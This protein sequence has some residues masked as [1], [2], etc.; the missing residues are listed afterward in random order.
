[1]SKS[2]SAVIKRRI[3]AAMFVI[4]F[5][6]YGILLVRLFQLQILESE[7]FQQEAQE[8]QFRVSELSAERGVIYDTNGNK[9]AMS[10][11]A[12]NICISPAEIKNDTQKELVISGLS[13]ILGVKE[14]YV[15][16]KCERKNY[17]QVIKA[18]VEKAAVEEVTTFAAANGLSKCIYVEENVSRKYPYEN[19]ASTVIGFL[20]A[21]NVASYGL[22]AYYDEILSGTSGKLI[23]ARDSW[24]QAMPFEYDELYSSEDGNS[25]VTTIDEGIQYFVEKHLELAVKEHSV[26][27]RGACIAMDVKTGKILAMATK[28]DFDPNLYTELPES[29]IEEIERLPEDERGDATLSAQYDMW[30][31]KAISDPYEPGS[32]FKIITLA[33]A[34]DANTATLGDH[35]SC[36]GYANVADRKISCWQS[37]G[38]GDQTLADAVQ[39]SC[40]P[41]FIQIGLNMGINNFEYY[42]EAFGLTEKTGIDL[43][44]EATSIYYTDGMTE[45]NLASSSFGQTFKVTPIQLVTAVSAAVNGGNLY[46]PY[47]VQKVLSSDGSI[48]EEYEPTLVRQVISEQ[49]S[50][51]VVDIL[52][53]V[54]SDGSGRTAA[55]P[56]Y[57]I[58]G[59][60]G[61]SEKLD[62][63]NAEG[64]VE[65]YVS[66]FLAVAPIEDPQIVIL[67]LLD[68]AQMENPYGSVVAAPV[69]GAMLADILPYM[70]IEPN[71]TEAELEAMTGKVKDVTENLV[72]DA[73]TTLRL[74]GYS[75]TIIGEGTTVV[76]QS[77]E[78]GSKLSAGGTITLYTDESL[79]P[80]EVEV[81]DVAGL[82]VTEV[83]NKIIGAGL[84]LKLI[85]VSESATDQVAY[86][87]TP[88]AGEMVMPGTI[89]EVSFTVSEEPPEGEG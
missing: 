21:E 29:V 44:G 89:I 86:M 87:Q 30:R 31:N 24:G 27:E 28:G 1:M 47:L 33:A 25:I 49:T 74:Q 10:S 75:V 52:E 82:S 11:T 36:I 81:P 15:R 71:Y 20:N 50:R 23:S 88:A 69:V 18:K 5:I 17:Y 22:E 55:V 45:I 12:W 16:E 78:A 65:N 46:K 39:N 34:L 9:L 54:V 40:N 2:P 51:T 43:P 19:F 63:V 58:G 7:K 56:G 6:G 60:T 3:L 26:R 14:D 37:H 57:R 79:I 73:M 35:Y 13:E 8:T 67:L 72:H 62:K 85:G 84:K 80:R 48:V 68:E 38:H 77:P 59:K 70:G 32:V 76:A 61:T 42:F 4:A 53:T 64:E 66:S 41:A 83:N